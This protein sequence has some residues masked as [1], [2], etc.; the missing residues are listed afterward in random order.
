[1]GIELSWLDSDERILFLRFEGKWTWDELYQLA[2]QVEAMT[3]EKPH[4]VYRIADISRSS[5][6]P[7]QGCS[8]VRNILSDQPIN[9]GQTYVVGSNRFTDVLL[10]TFSK[11][12]PE[13]AQ[14]LVLA[15]SCEAA[16]EMIRE[17]DS[18]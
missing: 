5:P 1:M 15:S 8:N 2:A 12:Y 11:V 7:P 10:S 18:A 13:Q 6:P 16:L 9:T 14:Y 4:R 17:A 3:L